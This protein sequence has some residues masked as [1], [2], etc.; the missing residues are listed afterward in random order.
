MTV[1]VSFGACL[2]TAGC[3]G[4]SGRRSRGALGGGEASLRLDWLICCFGGG[5]VG[6]YLLSNGWNSQHDD[7]R[8]QENQQQA[9]FAAGLC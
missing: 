8:H 1:S 7:E 3:D 4:S 2:V 6:K 5:G 9:A